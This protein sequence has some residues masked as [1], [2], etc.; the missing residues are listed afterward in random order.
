MSSA[1][2]TPMAISLLDILLHHLWVDLIV[3]VF[4]ITRNPTES[5]LEIELECINLNILILLNSIVVGNLFGDGYC[6]KFRNIYSEFKLVYNAEKH[7]ELIICKDCLSSWNK[8]D[9]SEN[10]D[11]L[12]QTRPVPTYISNSRQ[13]N[14]C[15]H[16]EIFLRYIQM[17]SFQILNKK[18]YPL[19]MLMQKLW[20][21]LNLKSKH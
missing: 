3:V 20:A 10:L 18:S 15:C 11:N 12:V 1:L 14:S 13:G 21:S 16:L 7:Q 4:R 5:C 2:V 6:Y 9:L 19:I 17:F 8:Y